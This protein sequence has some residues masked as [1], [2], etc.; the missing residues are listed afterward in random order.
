PP[1][2]EAQA[3]PLSSSIGGSSRGTS[4]PASASLWPSPSLSSSLSSSFSSSLSSPL[5]ASV[6]LLA[7]GAFGPASVSSLPASSVPTTPASSAGG[8]TPG[9][10][11]SQGVALPYS[12]APRSG[13]PSA[14]G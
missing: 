2:A 7:S 1:S 5:P 14:R 8:D 9:D 4:S 13:A 6:P 11:V 3:H 10:V 12:T